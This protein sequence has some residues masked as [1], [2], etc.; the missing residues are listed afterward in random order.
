MLH[1]LNYFDNLEKSMFTPFFYQPNP[2]TWPTAAGTTLAEAT[3]ACDAR[4]D[5][6]PAWTMCPAEFLTVT[7]DDAMEACRTDIWVTSLLFG[8]GTR[9]FGVFLH[10]PRPI[11]RPRLIPVLMELGPMIVPQSGYSGSRSRPMQFYIGF[12]TQFISIGLGVTLGIG[13]CNEP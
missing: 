5:M 12:C 1:L 2:L 6:D 8:V 4:F 10:W 7:R 9:S 3:S 11:P 13:Q